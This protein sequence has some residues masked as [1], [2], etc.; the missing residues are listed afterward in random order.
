MRQLSVH[1]KRKTYLVRSTTSFSQDRVKMCQ[2]QDQ[3]L[4]QGGCLK[5]GRSK[6]PARGPSPVDDNGLVSRGNRINSTATLLREKAWYPVNEGWR[7]HAKAQ[8][9]LPASSHPALRQNTAD[10]H[11]HRPAW[12]RAVSQGEREHLTYAKASVS[13]GSSGRFP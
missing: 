7:T 12:H 9:G 1:C 4:V 5:T 13:G 3:A 10:Q 8:R 11:T 2:T 6:G